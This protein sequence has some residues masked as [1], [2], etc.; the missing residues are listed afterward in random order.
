MSY[1]SQ[2]IINLLQVG[3]TIVVARIAGASVLGTIVFATSYVSMF[4]VFFDLGQGVAHIKLISGGREESACIGTFARIQIVLTLF[5]LIAALTVIYF[6]LHIFKKPFETDAHETV[7]YLTLAA[8]TLNNLYTIARTTFNARTEQAKA[9][10]PDLIKSFIYQILRLT[11]VLLGYK[12]VAISISNLAA[13]IIILPIILFFFKDIKVGR[14]DRKLFKEYSIIAAPVILLNFTEITSNYIDK[15]L[16]QYL[17]NSEEVGYYAAGLSIGGFILLI[18]NSLGTLLFPTFSKKIKE[19][20]YKSINSIIS[21][22]ERFIVLFMLPAAVS[23]AALSDVIVK[24]ALG[25]KYLNTIPILSAA[26][27]T[28]LFY[29]YF[30][31]YGNFITGKGKFKSVALFYVIKLVSLVF[32]IYIFVS[33]SLYNLRGFGLALSMFFSTL[34]LGICFTAFIFF[35]D[36]RVRIFPNGILII[37]TVLYFVT[38]MFLTPESNQAVKIMYVF[39]AVLIYYTGGYFAGFIEKKDFREFTDIFNIRKMRGYINDEIKQQGN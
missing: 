32:L 1:A 11:V 25:S 29:A 23:I 5:F 27:I 30:M 22:Y 10:L 7:I 8:I 28:S 12:A 33:P 31:I 21:K 36:K 6:Q 38:V 35:N 24:A 4:M 18:G 26:T 19:D 16:L 17:T 39:L 34:V 14:F 15:V 9:D 20:D 13:T 3:V 37:I 2:I